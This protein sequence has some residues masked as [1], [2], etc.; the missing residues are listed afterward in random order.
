MTNLVLVKDEG[1]KQLHKLDHV[2]IYNTDTVRTPTF[3]CKSASQQWQ[4]QA[5]ARAMVAPDFFFFLTPIKMKKTVDGNGD[6]HLSWNIQKS[7]PY[8]I[9]T[10][11]LHG[12]LPPKG[13]SVWALE[14]EWQWIY[15]AMTLLFFLFEHFTA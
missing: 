3:L 14:M 10:H 11:F 9:F 13:R 4:G 8:S 5:R 1:L 6:Y 12:L 15:W 2:F 7:Q